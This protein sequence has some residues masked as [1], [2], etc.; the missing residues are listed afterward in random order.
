MGECRLL[1]LGSMESRFGAQNEVHGALGLTGGKTNG[2]GQVAGHIKEV[3]DSNG[4]DTVNS[5]TCFIS[6]DS[7][8]RSSV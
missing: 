8:A 5:L 1:L 7:I 3:S 2:G 4:E 6:R